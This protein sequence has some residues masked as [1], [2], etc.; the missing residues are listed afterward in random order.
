MASDSYCLVSTPLSEIS[1]FPDEADIDDDYDELPI[2][3]DKSWDTRCRAYKEA[4]KKN[5][6]WK[7]I[8]SKLSRPGR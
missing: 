3:E 5:E 7:V 4:P 2:N 6:A 8:A 1:V